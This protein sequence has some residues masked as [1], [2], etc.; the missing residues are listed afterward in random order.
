MQS[1]PKF[2]CALR[3]RC[4]ANA[5]FRDVTRR[6]CAT[7]RGRRSSPF[8]Q[9]CRLQV[10][11][12]AEMAIASLS[13]RF[14]LPLQRDGLGCAAKNSPP[15]RTVHRRL[16]RPRDKGAF[17]WQRTGHEAF[18]STACRRRRRNPYPC[19][20]APIGQG[21]YPAMACSNAPTKWVTCSAIS[22]RCSR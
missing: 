20:A 10:G 21:A 11:T 15:C 1:T 2:S 4:A 6:I 19:Q 8:F 22:G 12:Q 17:N 14:L 18:P 5:G 13:I 9:P 7:S 16:I 3:A